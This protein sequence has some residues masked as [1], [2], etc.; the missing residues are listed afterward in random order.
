MAKGWKDEG[1]SPIENSPIPPELQAA[2]SALVK[3]EYREIDEWR[4]VTI[5]KVNAKGVQAKT[6]VDSGTGYEPIR[7]TPKEAI[8]IAKMIVES[9]GNSDES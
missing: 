1:F 6:Y 9:D 8:A 2:I 5:Y 7:F 3:A 4:V